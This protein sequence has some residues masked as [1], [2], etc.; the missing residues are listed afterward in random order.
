M[1]LSR[2]HADPV[3]LLRTLQAR[4]QTLADSASGLYVRLRLGGATFP[5]LIYYKVFTTQHV[6]DIGSFAPR[7]YA[8]DDKRRRDAK[9]ARLELGDGQDRTDVQ[10]W[11]Q[12][13]ENN[14]WRVVGGQLLLEH[15]EDDIE[16]STAA[17]RTYHHPN[18]HV[19]RGEAERRRKQRR[20]EWMK[21]LYERGGQSE[22]KAEQQQVQVEEA[23]ERMDVYQL[24]Y[25]LDEW[26]GKTKAGKKPRGEG[27]N[28][29][30][31]GCKSWRW[32]RTR[33]RWTRWWTG[34]I[35]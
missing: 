17:V 11:Y 8:L 27:S 4:D 18:K 21:Q 31:S 15:R 1:L 2:Q 30:S 32:R 3:L 29:S 35:S 13:W 7:H 12:R 9:K 22:A 10:Y 26:I 5:P 20:V 33:R 28:S 24:T 19:R 6:T 25:A 34:P 14:G 16:A 23:K